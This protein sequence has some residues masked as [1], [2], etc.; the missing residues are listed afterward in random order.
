MVGSLATPFLVNSDAVPAIIIP[1]LLPL[2]SLAILS[3]L[4]LEINAS[5]D[6]DRVCRNYLSINNLPPITPSD[7]RL[8]LIM[9]IKLLHTIK[10]LSL[11]SKYICFDLLSSVPHLREVAGAVAARCLQEVEAVVVVKVLNCPAPVP[12]F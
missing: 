12:G 7:F 1:L 2:S 8:L 3:S 5:P 4:S 6:S 9:N 10:I 11:L